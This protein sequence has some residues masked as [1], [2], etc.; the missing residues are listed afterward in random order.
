MTYASPNWDN[1]AD[2]HLLKLQRL[3]SRVLHAIGNP[4]RFTPL[5]ESHVAVKI[6]YV[7][8]YVNNY[9]GHGQ[10]YII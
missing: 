10:K 1:V 4:D 2:T 6:P 7:Y 5:R 8:D 3:Q 9:A